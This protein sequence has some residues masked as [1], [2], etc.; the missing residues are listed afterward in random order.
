MKT[1]ADLLVRDALAAQF[2]AAARGEASASA[3]LSRLHAWAETGAP[4]G[5]AADGLRTEHDDPL[6]DSDGTQLAAKFA[7]LDDFVRDRALRMH[8]AL[9]WLAEAN[10]TGDLIEA[11][12]A[13]W[14]AG[15]FFEV[16][17]LLE[18][19]WLREQGARKHALQGLILAGAALYHLTQD[20]LAGCR[21]LL[22][23]AE[24]RLEAHPELDGLH[25]A[26][27]GRALGAI[28]TRIAAG[29]LRHWSEIEELP[30][31]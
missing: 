7:A 4:L 29:E 25:L 19:E 28:G 18:P 27:F 16:H 23:D 11:S 5:E 31:F 13:A 3:R 6:F 14:D 20:N 12:R 8:A 26:E 22:G 30:R 2:V 1:R 10:T 9:A 21:G 24:R 15:L 17:E